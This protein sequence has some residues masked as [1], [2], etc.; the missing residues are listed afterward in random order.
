MQS[1][2]G[3]GPSHAMQNE[4]RCDVHGV[5]QITRDVNVNRFLLSS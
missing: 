1:V 3:S 2:S 4:M 5:M